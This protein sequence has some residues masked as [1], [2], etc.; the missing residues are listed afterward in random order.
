M[1]TWKI[2]F[3]ERKN[4]KNIEKCK[5]KERKK[6]Q[7]KKEGNPSLLSAIAGATVSMAILLVSHILDTPQ[8]QINSLATHVNQFRCTRSTNHSLRS[9]C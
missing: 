7:K 1:K 5:K 6:K 9:D 2:Y 8:L 4:V 3:S